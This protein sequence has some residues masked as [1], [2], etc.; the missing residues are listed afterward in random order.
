MEKTSIGKVLPLDAGW[1]DIG[2]WKAVWDDSPKDL[3]GNYSKAK[4]Y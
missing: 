1:N 3:D 4:S 2:S